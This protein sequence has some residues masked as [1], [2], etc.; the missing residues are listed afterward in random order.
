MSA[1][2]PEARSCK[3]THMHLCAL[4]DRLWLYDKVNWS[5]KW[6]MGDTL[7]HRCDWQDMYMAVKPLIDTQIDKD[8]WKDKMGNWA[9][10][11]YLKPSQ[12]IHIYCWQVLSNTGIC[13]CMQPQCACVFSVLHAKLWIGIPFPSLNAA[14]HPKTYIHADTWSQR[15][16]GTV[17]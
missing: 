7:Q 4:C 15:Q 9:Y 12:Y 3:G 2:C 13:A 10:T 8:V 6:V 17:L 16:P 14:P 11:H 1:I 5:L